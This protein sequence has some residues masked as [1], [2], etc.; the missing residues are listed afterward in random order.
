MLL[1]ALVF[2]AALCGGAATASQGGARA[3]RSKAAREPLAGQAH[4]TFSRLAVDSAG[5]FHDMA[6]RAVPDGGFTRPPRAGAYMPDGTPVVLFSDA[7]LAPLLAGRGTGSTAAP[8]AAGCQAVSSGDFQAMLAQVSRQL[9]HGAGPGASNATSPGQTYLCEWRHESHTVACVLEKHP[10]L[11]TVEETIPLGPKPSCRREPP[12]NANA[13]APHAA[14][15]RS[16]SEG[17]LVVREGPHRRAMLHFLCS[18]KLPAEART[19]SE[20]RNDTAPRAPAGSDN[21]E[22]PF[23]GS[24]KLRPYVTVEEEAKLRT[25]ARKMLRVLGNAACHCAADLSRGSLHCTC[26]RTRQGPAASA[27]AGEAGSAVSTDA[28]HS[29]LNGPVSHSAAALASSNVSAAL[30]AVH[31][32][33]LG[34]RSRMYDFWSVMQESRSVSEGRLA[35][36]RSVLVEAS[37]YTLAAIPIAGGPSGIVSAGPLVDGAAIA[38][39]QAEN[40]AAGGPLVH[41]VYPGSLSEAAKAAGSQPG[42][43]TEDLPAGVLAMPYRDL[44]PQLP[45]LVEESPVLRPVVAAVKR[46]LAAVTPPHT[47]S[48]AAEAVTMTLLARR[49]RA[50]AAELFSVYPPALS[51]TAALREF[52]QPV[53]DDSSPLPHHF[54]RSGIDRSP[55]PIV[56]ARTRQLARDVT[57]LRRLASLAAARAGTVSNTD[58]RAVWRAVEAVIRRRLALGETPAAAATSALGADAAASLERR[59]ED[60]QEEDWLAS[61]AEAGGQETAATVRAGEAARASGE[62]APGA[63]GPDPELDAR[64]EALL[65]VLADEAG[66]AA[67]RS[68]SSPQ[69]LAVVSRIASEAHSTSASGA[70]AEAAVRGAFLEGKGAGLCVMWPRCTS[71]LGG[72]PLQAWLIKRVAAQAPAAV[73]SSGRC[74]DGGKV[75]GIG[76]AA[77]G[78]GAALPLGPGK[79]SVTGAPPSDAALLQSSAGRAAS[80][81]A[82]LPLPAFVPSPTE[83]G[84]STDGLLTLRR[85]CDGGGPMEISREAI[86]ALSGIPTAV[87]AAFAPN[88]KAGAA[89]E[90]DAGPGTPEEAAAEAAAEAAKEAAAPPSPSASPLPVPIRA[91]FDVLHGERALDAAAALGEWRRAG[92]AV[93]NLGN[94][95]WSRSVGKGAAP[96]KLSLPGPPKAP[97]EEAAP[98]PPA[99]SAAVPTPKPKP[100]V[101][102]GASPLDADGSVVPDAAPEDSPFAADSLLQTAVAEAEGAL[103]HA[104][105]SGALDQS[106]ADAAPE[107][108]ASLLQAWASAIRRSG[109]EALAAAVEAD[110][111][112]AASDEALL[113]A[114]VA[115]RAAGPGSAHPNT[116]NE[117]DDADMD[118]RERLLANAASFRFQRHGARDAPGLAAEALGGAAAAHQAQPQ[119]SMTAVDA[120]MAAVTAAEASERAPGPANVADEEAGGPLVR[121][122][123]ADIA[124]AARSA[125]RRVASLLV[126]LNGTL[127]CLCLHAGTPV[128]GLALPPQP[129]ASLTDA[130]AAS[131]LVASLGLSADP[132]AGEAE[133]DAEVARIEDEEA[134]GRAVAAVDEALNSKAAAD[135][136]QGVAPKSI[137]PALLQASGA[138]RRLRGGFAPPPPAF[139]EHARPLYARSHDGP[140]SHYLAEAHGEGDG[141]VLPSDRRGRMMDDLSAFFTALERFTPRVSREAGAAF[142]GPDLLRAGTT[143][144]SDPRAAM[145]HSKESQRP[146]GSLPLGLARSLLVYVARERERQARWPAA[147]L[148]MHQARVL[149][150]V[151]QQRLG[152]ALGKA[153]MAGGA[154]DQARPGQA[155]AH[156]APQAAAASAHSAGKAAP[157]HAAPAVA[158]AAPA[159]SLLELEASAARAISSVGR[160]AASRRRVESQAAAQAAA[161]RRALATVVRTLRAPGAGAPMKAMPTAEQL[162]SEAAL[163][164]LLPADLIGDTVMFSG[165]LAQL[166][167]TRLGL[168]PSN[169]VDAGRWVAARMQEWQRAFDAEKED[170]TG[171]LAALNGEAPWKR[172]SQERSKADAAAG[173]HRHP[174]NSWP[175]LG[176]NASVVS[177]QLRKLGAQHGMLHS[178]LDRMSGLLSD[179]MQTLK[180]LLRKGIARA[181]AAASALGSALDTA[182]QQRQAALDS[183]KT[184]A[185]G[186]SGMLGELKGAIDSVAAGTLATGARPEDIAACLAEVSSDEAARGEG[187]SMAE[188]ASEALQVLAAA[189]RELAAA[190]EAHPSKKKKHSHD[191]KPPQEDS[192]LPKSPAEQKLAKTA[193]LLSGRGVISEDEH[194]VVVRARDGMINAEARAIAAALREHTLLLACLRKR[195]SR[196]RGAGAAAAARNVSGAPL[197]LAA[198]NSTAAAEAQR[199]AAAD[200][201]AAHKRLAEERRLWEEAVVRLARPKT[202]LQLQGLAT[203]GTDGM[204]TIFPPDDVQFRGVKVYCDMTTDGGGWT[205]VAYGQEGQVGGP[206][207]VSHGMYDPVNRSASAGLNAL[208]VAQAS[209]EVALSWMPKGADAKAP[210]SG[211]MHTYGAAAAYAVPIP[212][213]TDLALTPAPPPQTCVSDRG[214][215][216]VT[217]VRCLAMPKK[218]DAAEQARRENQ[219]QA[220][221]AQAAESGAAP[222]EA[223]DALGFGGDAGNGVDSSDRKAVDGSGATL[224]PPQGTQ[225]EHCKLPARMYTGTQSLGVCH[226]HAYGV[227]L[228]GAPDQDCDGPLALGE[229]G[230]KSQPL[231]PGAP[232]DAPRQGPA[233][234][235][236]MVGVDGTPGCA[237]VMDQGRDGF[238]PRYVAVWMR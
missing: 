67:A 221:A 85:W 228:R 215:Y 52:S 162:P 217:T 126:R 10:R 18:E 102:E 229:G 165:G 15:S 134:A 53:E 153:A 158:G 145:P 238:M 173:L 78:H 127:A 166:T 167:P 125:G 96:V 1:A 155:P 214:D 150:D 206:M 220:E 137:L 186:V 133:D 160:A 3:L 87:A 89:T 88:F 136:A 194:P 81:H 114:T 190:L 209:K 23:H 193:E 20:L 97:Q 66:P 148:D 26:A 172:S 9:S 13:T 139:G 131:G 76:S 171:A 213:T 116:V 234:L 93:H 161:R 223:N 202:C 95:G 47:A 25:A 129:P 73:P 181:E 101:A 197:A 212:A 203:G 64:D 120:V 77:A 110:A 51:S 175:V 99:A 226:G 92:R 146:L 48:A 188:S 157:S 24:A 4:L 143:G 46:S 34:L 211:P 105:A 7:C 183:A 123:P 122:M 237:G 71:L 168:P 107:G 79:A 198:V 225:T 32:G 60:A 29:A 111:D 74:A 152:H 178:E 109:H 199:S 6:K 55:G 84:W 90:Q 19:G 142:A 118:P 170:V 208:W 30:E 49:L 196:L 128:A 17:D 65:Q 16:A 28:E 40:A 151:A 83:L 33:R 72:T 50:T 5:L 141:V 124:A 207:G 176:I 235:G 54:D 80:G 38:A 103:R 117:E 37:R 231:V 224:P 192:A 42:M 57:H 195:G 44:G 182:A 8:L 14:A 200:L 154:G 121:R 191:H 61:V 98:K 41:G 180:D 75:L 185:Q 70:V 106:A 94:L 56:A 112:A 138:S 144:R 216:T 227:V 132:G 39:A 230:S 68:A 43:A 187:N 222:A 164:E 130:S 59:E 140:P 163:D 58:P 27:T 69:H 169:P 159:A 147:P 204:Y 210:P 86:T 205:L 218:A 12:A 201:A 174:K 135:A 119:D 11:V 31:R 108:T 21:P 45:I 149:A 36:A 104:L 189:R 179:R 100:V 236:L 233:Q 2:A 63:S 22:A 177:G 113:A 232:A 82:P 91:D 62:A 184:S 35:H 156:P 115:K 219:R